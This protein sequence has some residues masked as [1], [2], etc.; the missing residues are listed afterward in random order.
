M[1]NQRLVD[2]FLEVAKI[3]ALSGNEKPIAD[4]IKSFIS[5]LGYQVNEDNS[6]EFT[7]SNTGNLICKIGSGGN[8][9]MLSHMDTAR[10]TENVKPIILEDKITSSGDT[11]LGVDN[12]AGI[13]V[14]L[15]TLEKIAQEK[16]PVKDFTVAFTTCEETTLFGSKNLGVN[17]EIKHG[18]IFDSGYR[19]GNFI[20]SAC[21]A[22]GLKIKIIGKASHSGISPEKGINSMLVAAKAI[23]KLPLGRIDEETTMNIGLLKSGSAVNVIPELTELEGEVR[24][25]NLQKAENYFNQLVEIFNEESKKIGA[26]IEIDSFWDFMPYTILETSFVFKETVRAIKKVGLEPTPKISLGG[27]DANSLN[28][29]GIES[30]NLGIGA[31]NPH[32]NDEFIYLEDLIKSAEIALELVKKE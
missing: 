32:S 28:G 1:N 19:P 25:F 13:S 29:R 22:I 30:I 26:K 18:F 12:R 8:F 7:K 15:Y 31:Q 16:I 17:G 11:V 10:P 14:L 6:R 20:F 4:Y 24:S 5:D 2:L 21:G 27:S 23:S 3:N 9:V